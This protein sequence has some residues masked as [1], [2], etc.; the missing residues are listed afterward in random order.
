MYVENSSP[1]ALSESVEVSVVVPTY[2]HAAFIRSTIE[3]ILAQETDFPFEILVGDDASP[4]GTAAILHEL[5]SAHPGKLRVL[6]FAANVGPHRNM[7][8][9]ITASR[10]KYI[11][12]C[13][14]DDV[15]TDPVKLA[16]QYGVLTA[17]PSARLIYH[18]AGTIDAEGRRLAHRIRRGWFSRVVTANEVILGDGG[19]IP[20]SSML[21]EKSLMMNEPDWQ[22][23]APVG[24]YPLGI[25]AA[26]EGEVIYLDREMCDYRMSVPHS[27]TQ[28]HVA[29]FE[30][31]LD[32]ARRIDT[33]LTGVAAEKPAYRRAVTSVVS[34]YYSDVLV[35]YTTD[36]EQQSRLYRELR[37]RMIGFDRLLAWLAICANIRLPG[38]KDTLRKIKTFSRLVRGHL[39]TRRIQPH[40]DLGTEASP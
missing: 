4:D 7:A 5:Q 24:D 31:R 39:M 25:R 32:Y 38:L 12:H 11:A 3:G 21:I 17:N 29:T 8:A 23:D 36:A 40:V 14:G 10:A 13:D 9:L 20:T 33:M 16:L 37:T 27:W 15:W 2:K 1:S 6:S 18:A 19:L 28:R 22:R 35:R 26:I 34:K 30:N